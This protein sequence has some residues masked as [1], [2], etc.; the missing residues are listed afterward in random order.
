MQREAFPVQV[1]SMLLKLQLFE[2]LV[3]GSYGEP[4]REH[5]PLD[6]IEKRHL[7]GDILDTKVSER[8]D[9]ERAEW[10][11]MRIEW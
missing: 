8:R 4:S 2:K 3:E 5:F 11:V 9:D 7:E 1:H 10:A 6:F